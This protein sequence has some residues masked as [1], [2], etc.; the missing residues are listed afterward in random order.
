M[1]PYPGQVPALVLGSGGPCA[2]QENKRLPNSLGVSGIFIYP[3]FLPILI[4]SD[5]SPACSTNDHWIV[6]YGRMIF[7]FAVRLHLSQLAKWWK[8]ERS[9]NFK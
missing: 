9:R 2:G 7:S 8:F 3:P 5:G 1:G 6:D 4:A